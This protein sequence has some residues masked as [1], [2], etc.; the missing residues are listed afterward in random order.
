RLM[1]DLQRLAE[2]RHMK[3]DS[4]HRMTVYHLLDRRFESV[5]VEE[6]AKAIDEDV[7][8]NLVIGA[9]EAVINQ[10]CLQGRHRV[11]R[12]RPFRKLQPVIAG[13]EV[14]G[15]LLLLRLQARAFAILQRRR[16]LSNRLKAEEII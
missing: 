6:S 8:V 12:F 3:R 11:S 7:A 4:Q 9:V 16:Q 10:P 1:D 13:D 2:A 5:N 15:A 14:K